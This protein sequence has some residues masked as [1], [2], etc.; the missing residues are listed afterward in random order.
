VPAMTVMETRRLT[1][2][3]S[4]T[5]V[6][7]LFPDL[8]KSVAAP[9]NLGLGLTYWTFV[10]SRNPFFDFLEHHHSTHP[11]TEIHTR[12]LDSDKLMWNVLAE[13][14]GAQEQRKCSCKVT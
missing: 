13:E 5:R 8:R 9:E 3:R 1:S 12:K 7:S 2:D 14:R 6:L 10:G 4:R 11:T